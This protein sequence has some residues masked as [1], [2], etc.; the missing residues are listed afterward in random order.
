MVQVYVFPII[1]FIPN[2][3]PTAIWLPGGGNERSVY[4]WSCWIVWCLPARLSSSIKERTAHPQAGEGPRKG[5]L[6][7]VSLTTLPGW[8][9]APNRTSH[10]YGRMRR[11]IVFVAWN[12]RT[13]LDLHG[14]LLSW[15]RNSVDTMSTLLRLQ[16]HG[17]LLDD[18]SLT[19]AG[20]G[21]TFF[22]KGLP[23]TERRIHGVGFAV[24]NSLCIVLKEYPSS[25]SARLMKLR[26]PL[27][28]NR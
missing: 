12:V 17:Y 2:E 3:R 16:R 4:A 21:Y 15:R 27:A 8:E 13:M 9:T 6:Q 18:G 1:R 25:I 28:S 14:E 19:E 26:L 11:K 22:W 5:G 24:R 10:Y 23:Q 20:G 7:I